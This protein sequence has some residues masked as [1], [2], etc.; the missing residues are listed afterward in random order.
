[1]EAAIEQLP[2]FKA[3]PIEVRME[4]I[5]TKRGSAKTSF[6]VNDKKAVFVQAA[7]VWTSWEKSA[8]CRKAL[9]DLYSSRNKEGFPLG[10]QACFVPYT[11]DSRFITTPKTAQN[12]ERMKSKQKRFNDQ[13]STARNFT[14]IGLDYECP[15]LGVTLR[16]VLM[17][18]RSS[19]QPERKLFVAVDQMTN[20]SSVVMAFHEDLE[21]EATTVIPA[22]PII[23]EAKY[24]P[25]AWTWFNEDAKEYSAGYRWDTTLGLVSTEDERTNE[26]LAEWSSDEELDGDADSDVDDNR[27]SVARIELF[28]IV[29]NK[30][31][32]NQYNDNYSIGTFKTAG[33]P[34]TT[35]KTITGSSA[36]S[37]ASTAPPSVET[38]LISP[39]TSTLSNEYQTPRKEQFNRWCQDDLFRIQAMEWLTKT[40][41]TQTK[42]MTLQ[43]APVQT[44]PPTETTPVLPP[45]AAEDTN[46]DSEKHG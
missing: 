38:S 29:L 19:S 32:N 10:I 41:T 39:S 35:T 27:Q 5:R 18:L 21:Q 16:E 34:T 43:T 44:V 13:T 17:G 4:P 30:P 2:E 8:A 14:I 1:L 6:K 37:T 7:H 3:I 24:G 31:G 23:I 42:N 11:L 20:Y 15:D 45:N 36:S 40:M 25:S 26:I 28:N 46:T 12:V 9:S 22:L 33:D